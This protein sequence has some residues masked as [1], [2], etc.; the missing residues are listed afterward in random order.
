MTDITFGSIRRSRFLN[1]IVF[2]K[3]DKDGQKFKQPT[4]DAKPGYE[5]LVDQ[6]IRNKV[7]MDFT[8]SSFNTIVE[9]DHDDD[10]NPVIVKI[11]QYCDD[12]CTGLWTMNHTYFRK[13][14]YDP[15]SYRII[16][17]EKGQGRIMVHFE[18][19]ADIEPFLKNC[20]VLL[21]LSS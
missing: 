19:E 7:K 1:R 10:I 5:A 3:V 15:V 16:N 20:A 6:F 21:K 11:H 9:H 14:E 18:N 12:N 8:T 2:E 13:S 17:Q 4:W